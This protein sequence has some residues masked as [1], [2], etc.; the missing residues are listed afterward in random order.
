MSVKTQSLGNSISGTTVRKDKHQNKVQEIN[1]QLRNLCQ[2]KNVNFIDYGKRTKT[3]HL[4]KSRLHVTRT[5]TI[6]LSTT[7]V[8][9]I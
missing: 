8:R 2:V 5:G 3:Q 7:F 4:N 6:I 9:K 1:H